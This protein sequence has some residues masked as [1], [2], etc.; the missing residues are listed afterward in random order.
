MKGEIA[1]ALEISGRL[2]HAGADPNEMLIE[3]LEFCHYV[4]RVKI[5]PDA[6]QD[7]TISEPSGAARARLRRA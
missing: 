5:S 3:L 1:E 6:L 7:V 2:Y 4:T